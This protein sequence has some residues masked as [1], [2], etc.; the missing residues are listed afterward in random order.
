MQKQKLVVISDL[1]LWGPHDPLYR[2]LIR[3]LD[4]Y[5]HYNDKLFIV[6]DLFDLFVGNKEY[7]KNKYK[8]LLSKLDHLK[9]KNIEVFYIEGNHDFQIEGVFQKMK[10][11]HVYGEELHYEFFGKK[12]YFSHG[13]MINWGDFGYM[14]WRF[15]TRSLVTQGIIEAIPGSILGKLG[16]KL[17]ITSREYSFKKNIDVIKI[18]RNF[19][20]EKIYSGYDYVVLGHSHFFDN[21]KFRIGEH[22]G[23]YINC[24][25]PRKNRK[26]FVLE[27]TQD[28][29]QELSIEEYIGVFTP[30]KA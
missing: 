25:F 4:S 27:S 1:H 23:Q 20:C 19:A 26:F 5:L 10:H 28:E 18:F 3:F 11:F 24:G 13:D 14:A 6:G 7:F 16:E 21:I 30:F 17:S 2:G 9:F 8:E 15:F 22:K 12:I 29:F